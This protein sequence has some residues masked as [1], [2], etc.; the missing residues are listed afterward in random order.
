[1]VSLLEELGAYSRRWLTGLLV[2]GL[3]LSL[4]LALAQS[5][6]VPGLRRLVPVALLAAALGLWAGG[7][8]RGWWLAPAAALA[9][10]AVTLAA[11]ARA[12][13]LFGGSSERLADA[14]HRLGW[15]A[16]VLWLGGATDDPLMPLLAAGLA[17]WAV[18]FWLGW[19][20]LRR[21]RALPAVLPV[22]AI[23]ATNTFF[24]LGGSAFLLAFPPVAL[25]LLAQSRAHTLESECSERGGVYPARLTARVLAAALTVAA[26]VALVATMAPFLSFDT[27]SEAFWARAER[28]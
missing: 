24:G 3:S 17:V 18:C 5:D 13:P 28:P 1:M 15:W 21:D 27:L 19:A 11:A 14:V 26:V 9:G 8:R 22:G 10:F 7:R 12:W 25:V 16:Q 4:P 23:L 20:I 6:W 2:L